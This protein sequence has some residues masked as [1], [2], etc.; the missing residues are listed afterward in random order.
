MNRPEGI[1]ESAWKAAKAVADTWQSPV[2]HDH[3]LLQEDVARAIQAA[4]EA[5][6]ERCARH[7]N[8]GCTIVDGEPLD[9]AIPEIYHAITQGA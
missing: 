6:R 2:H 1:S 7:L 9:P 8:D 4:Q 3:Q 5:E